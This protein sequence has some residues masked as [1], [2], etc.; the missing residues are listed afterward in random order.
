MTA[1]VW[2]RSTHSGPGGGDCIEVAASAATVRIRGPMITV[3]PR[4][5][6]R[7]LAHRVPPR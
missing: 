2:R 1:P 3:S 5:W 4:T 6:A 7:C